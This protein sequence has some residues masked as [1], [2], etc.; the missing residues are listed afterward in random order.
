M[1]TLFY[2]S[3]ILVLDNTSIYITKSIT[4]NNIVDE[5]TRWFFI[6]SI[7]NLYIS[8]LTFSDVISCLNDPLNCYKI[9]WTENSYNIFNFSIIMHVY[10]VLFFKLNSADKMHHSLMCG[11]C[12]PLSYLQKNIIS[13]CALFFLTGFPGFI[14][15]FLLY[16]VKINKL[17]KNIEKKIYIHLSTWIR[18]PGLCFTTLVV[19]HALKS[20][21]YENFLMFMFSLING[22]LI[23]WNGQYYMMITCIDYGIKMGK[24]K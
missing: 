18:S 9:S 3:F 16:L 8:L 5:N 2:I 19:V 15:Y 20:I 11:I 1:I 10:H 13:T 12:G 14:D 17:D 4:K 21:Y 22:F 7:G 24:I 23:F 6:H